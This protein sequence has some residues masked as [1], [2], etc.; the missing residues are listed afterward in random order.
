MKQELKD[1]IEIVL[2]GKKEAITGAAVRKEQMKVEVQE[3]LENEKDQAYRARN[4][5]MVGVP[6]PDT[7]DLDERNAT[8][9]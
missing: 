3:V 9:L 8:D 5:I 6:E 2:Q 1:E 4:L 7:D